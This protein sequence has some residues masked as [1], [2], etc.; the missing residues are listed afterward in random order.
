MLAA[1]TTLIY[2]QC[3]PTDEGGTLPLPTSICLTTKHHE[4]P[5]PGMNVLLK[6]NIDTFPGYYNP[7]EYYDTLLISDAQGR[8]CVGAV[9]LGKHW[10]VAL[11]VDEHAQQIV[12]VY[13][14]LP[15]VIDLEKRMKVDTVVY[16]YE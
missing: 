3:R 5:V 11:G 8:V 4:I 7:I 13:G 9:P 16:L 14:R 15:I 10:A 6:Y 1:F 2:T 12:P